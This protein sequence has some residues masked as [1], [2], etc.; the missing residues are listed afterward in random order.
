MDKIFIFIMNFKSF[1]LTRRLMNE[2]HLQTLVVIL[3]SQFWLL[4]SWS[5]H[6]LGNLPNIKLVKCIRQIDC[7]PFFFAMQYTLKPRYK[8]H[9]E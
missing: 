7:P 2:L 9:S 6:S 5:S 4:R 3:S 1:V 8:G